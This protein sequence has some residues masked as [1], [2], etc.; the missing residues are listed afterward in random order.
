MNIILGSTSPRRK[1]ILGTLFRNFQVIAP[2]AE[3]NHRSGETPEE[4]AVRLSE[5]KCRSIIEAGAVRDYPALVISSD[6]IVT[7][8]GAIIGKPADHDDAVRA[9]SLLSGRTHRVITGLTLFAAGGP[10]EPF[11]PVT[12]RETTEVTFRS[13]DRAGI[14][15]YLASI[16]YRDKAGSYAF[17][18]NGAMIIDRYRGSVTNIIGF[19]LRL[20]FAMLSGMGLLD[21]LFRD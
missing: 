11:R 1:D 10:R 19:P 16:V 21:N 13:L 6:T 8:D 5:D 20:F 15:R 18:D 4:F 3:E 14:E 12:A 9:I 17:Q 7:I 2:S